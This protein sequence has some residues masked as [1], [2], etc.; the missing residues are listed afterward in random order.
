MITVVR[1]KVSSF[2]YM[3]IK[4][5]SNNNV[6]YFCKYHVV[7]CSKY[8]RKVLVGKIETRLKELIKETC[9][10]LKTDLIELEIMPD[11]CP[12]CG[13]RNHANDR[14]YKCSCGFKIHRD[15]LGAKN[16]ISAP[17][18]DGNSLSA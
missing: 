10:E 18:V 17:V 6:A 2:N 8:R 14:K 12:I 15:I 16:I 13:E 11:L 5:K 9:M 1:R 4:Y 3:D 7:W